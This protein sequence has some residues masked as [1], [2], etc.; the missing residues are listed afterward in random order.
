[1][2]RLKDDY[3]SFYMRFSINSFLVMLKE[4][5]QIFGFIPRSLKFVLF[6]AGVAQCT[7]KKLQYC[8]LDLLQVVPATLHKFKVWMRKLE[9]NLAGA[10]CSLD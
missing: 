6:S 4:G 8:I 1:M 9:V 3:Q 2:K 10:V 7:D 5:M